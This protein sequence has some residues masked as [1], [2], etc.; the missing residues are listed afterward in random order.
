MPGPVP[1]FAP[2]GHRI[3]SLTCMTSRA[4]RGAGLGAALLALILAAAADQG[5]AQAQKKSAKKAP[6]KGSAALVRDLGEGAQLDWTRG[7]LVARGAAAGDLRAPSPNVARLGA[8]RG[9]RDAARTRLRDLAMRT[10]LAG[11]GTVGQAL[12]KDAA[13]A[14]RLDRALEATIDLDVD[15]G[16]DG[17]VVLRTALPLEAVRA[18]LHGPSPM[19]VGAPAD[20][21]TALVVTGARLPGGPALGLAISAGPERYAGPTLFLARPPQAGDP[22]IGERPVRVRAGKASGGA[23]ELTGEGA[24]AV[25]ESARSAGALVVI[26][27]EK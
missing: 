20:A 22:R 6:R 17:S 27:Q 24:A 5:S 16:T 10:P 21:P 12:K 23:I 15:L 11:G 4:H 2:P 9:A 26:V 19:P 3:Y 1:A 18:A 14:S 7:L 8:E 25:L 13:A